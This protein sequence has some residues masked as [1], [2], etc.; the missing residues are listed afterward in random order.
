MNMPHAR[1]WSPLVLLLVWGGVAP[2]LYAQQPT[3]AGAESKRPLTIEDLYLF[4]GPE[5]VTLAPQGD[6]AVYVRHW[7]DRDTKTDRYSLWRVDADGGKRP[8]EP[9]EPD[10]RSPVFSPD[11]RWLALRSTRARPDG[12]GAIPPTPPQSEAATDI[13]LLPAAGGE[14][15]ALCSGEVKV[16]GRV[17]NDLFYGR[18][19]FSPDG[20]KLVFVAD[21]GRD[22][23][24]AEELAAG[25]EIVR[26]D[27]GEGYTG[28][29][30]AQIW[31]AHLVDDSQRPAA[32]RIERL[33]DDDVWYGDPQWSPDGRW[34]VVHANRTLDREA[35]RYSI[36]KNYDL[37][38]IDAADH[39]LKQLTSGPGPEV[40]PRFSPDGRRLACLSS[41]RKGPHADV[42]N[43]ALVD[44]AAAT[45]E[46]PSP[47]PAQIL[48]D[49]HNRPEQP[50]DDPAPTFPLLEDCFSGADELVY[51]GVA[52]LQSA[53]MRVDLKTWRREPL[54]APK[55]ANTASNSA[56]NSA[57]GAGEYARR[58]ARRREL[59]P[60]GNAFLGQRLLG[61]SRRVEWTN[62]E[63]LELDG[64]LTVPHESIARPPYKL[65]LHPHG[66]PHSRSSPGLN[67]TA[68]IFA[69]QGYAVFEPN[70]RGSAGYGRKFLDAD[71]KDFGG[72]DM[73]DIASGIESLAAQK[74]VDPKRQFVYGVSYGGFMTCWL[75]GHTAQ[76]RAAVAQNAVTDLNVM[77]ALS[78]IQSWTEWEFG[79]KPW[80]TAEMMRVHSPLTYAADVVTPTL[81]LHSRDDRRCPIAM[82]RMFYQALSDRG[83]PT[84][85]VIYPDEG[86]GIRQPRHREDVLRRTLAWF[87]QHDHEP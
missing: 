76:F 40:S 17:F 65:V 66:G 28:Y 9:G 8:L 79:G 35:V 62:A 33:T 75:V 39:S 87:A 60:A 23:H 63:G 36:N 55:A 72:G 51:T 34:L 83:V 29:G 86:H 43:L 27:Q 1:R 7:I 80:E 24:T 53:T 14:A 47:Q 13:W 81:I 45:G 64:V 31:V 16:Y 18:V 58:A 73:R 22:R 57:S 61:E 56:S 26:P 85:M 32:E 50:A 11:G 77:W 48:F 78:D 25:V 42:F 37:W 70:F 69:A 38:A 84:G 21:D 82:G 46:G 44:F 68:Q 52:G 15:V 41:P 4:D 54:L 19:A 67:F 59:T 74:L 10:A 3:P 12:Q 2:A 5:S 49:F 71:R 30:N 20:R 6:F